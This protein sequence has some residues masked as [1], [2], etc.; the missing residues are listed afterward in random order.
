M[1]NEGLI[2]IITGASSGIGKAVALKLAESKPKIVIVARRQKELMKTAHAVKRKG[3]KVLPI[4]GDVR[5][6]EDR[7]RVVNLT[8]KAFGYIDVLINNAGLGKANLFIDQPDEEINEL[9]ETN[10]L[11]L[12]KLTHEVLPIMKNQGKGHIINLS[13]TLALLPTYPFAVYCATKAAVKTFSDC[14]REEVKEHGINISTVYPGP[15]DTGFGKVA[16]YGRSGF[17]GY[18]ALKLAEH[19]AKLVSKPKDNLIKPWFFVPLVWVTKFSRRL[20][21]KV[22]AGIADEIIKAK[23][24]TDLTMKLE[25]EK[26]EEIEILAR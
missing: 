26:Q 13:S 25:E 16:G 19:I 23:R 21:R 11:A 5:N 20:K 1:N 22:I 18:D 7:E 3:A 6:R 2:I 4:I 17:Q 8:M 12:I 10:I 14:I 24:E 15:Y 9:I